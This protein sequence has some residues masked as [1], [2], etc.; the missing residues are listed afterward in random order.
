[1]E[2]MWESMEMGRGSITGKW[3]ER[4]RTDPNFEGM[5]A[6]ENVYV[7]KATIQPQYNDKSTGDWEKKI[8]SV[9]FDS[10]RYC[11]TGVVSVAQ[12]FCH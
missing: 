5:N 8:G 11:L 7:C 2:T 10:S 9:L 4:F 12:L 6:D 3:G 1:M